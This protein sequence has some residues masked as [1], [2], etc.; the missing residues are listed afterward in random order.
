MVELKVVHRW[1][2][3]TDLNLLEWRVEV[4]SVE[5]EDVWSTV[6]AVWPSGAVEA[7]D[8]GPVVAAVRGEGVAVR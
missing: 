7:G 8:C 4:W 3:L 5:V 2:C 6:V 1:G